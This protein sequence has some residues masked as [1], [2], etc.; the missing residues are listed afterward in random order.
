MTDD[1]EHRRLIVAGS[2]IAGLTAAIYAARSNNDPLVLEG[3]EPGGQLTL[4]TDVANYPGFPDGISGP[5]LVN[6]MKEQATQFGAE[7]DHGVVV[8]L[9]RKGD[10][11]FRV[12]LRDGTVYTADAFIAASGA[13]ARTLG[14]PGEDELMGYGVSTCATCDGA[15]F[16]GE[17]ML[18]VGGGDAAMEEAN[19]LTKFASKVYVVHRRE[20]FRAEDYWIDRT[21]EKVEEGEIE[22]LRNT[23][24]L[25]IEGTPDE[26]VRTVTLAEN[27]EG[28]PS[29]KL[30]DPATEQYEM[31]VGAVFIAIGHTPNTD[32]LE[33][34]G[35][36][37]TDDGYLVTEAGRGAGQTKTGVPGL[38]GA[39][40]V[41]DFH[42]QQAVTAAGMGSKA[43]IDADEYLED[44]ERDQQAEAEAAADD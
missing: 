36:E 41:V 24:L 28:Y 27:P 8:D 7:I 42:Y 26:G 16:R 6:D 30:D 23:E 14:I 18:V 3:V 38:F 4:T 43:A 33:G 13:S 39:G 19:F 34:M 21:M 31:D 15:F 32:Y 25:E 17:E 1:A 2:G 11:R 5:D 44:L 35:V 9:E 10:G 22:L 40:D 29:E 12:E 37:M 20:E